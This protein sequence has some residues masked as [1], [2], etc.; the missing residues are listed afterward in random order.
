M[1][2]LPTSLSC[3]LEN[4]H[5]HICRSYNRI[6]DLKHL[7]NW[8]KACTYN[9]L[10]PKPVMVPLFLHLNLAPSLWDYVQ[11]TELAPTMD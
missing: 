1:A 7:V 2:V 8:P 4:H 10:I 11:V 5:H 9:N 3:T 6:K